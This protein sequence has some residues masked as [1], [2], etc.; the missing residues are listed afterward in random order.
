MITSSQAY[1][2][3]IGTIFCAGNTVTTAFYLMFIFEQGLALQIKL[4]LL[5]FLH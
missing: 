4:F 1:R 2:C 5:T 3:D